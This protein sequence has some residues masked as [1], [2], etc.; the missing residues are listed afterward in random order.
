MAQKTY[1]LEELTK[2]ADEHR[3]ALER[4]AGILENIVKALTPSNVPELT[5]EHLQGLADLMSRVHTEQ[6]RARASTG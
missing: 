1:T 2:M 3:E 6:E 4:I 5:A